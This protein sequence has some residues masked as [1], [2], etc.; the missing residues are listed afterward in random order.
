MPTPHNTP[1]RAMPTTAALVS[2]AA[3]LRAAGWTVPDHAALRPHAAAQRRADLR[4]RA[5]ALRAVHS[6]P[7]VWLPVALVLACAGI[8]LVVA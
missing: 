7:G 8:V 3:Q 6:L 4:A 2:Q 5:R 1:A